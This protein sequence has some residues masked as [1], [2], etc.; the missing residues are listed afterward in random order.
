MSRASS[1]CGLRTSRRQYSRCP[2]WTAAAGRRGPG[3]KPPRHNRTTPAEPRREAMTVWTQRSSSLQQG[4]KAPDILDGFECQHGFNQSR[5]V[6]RPDDRCEFEPNQP[7]TRMR[8]TRGS[9]RRPKRPPLRCYPLPDLRC[10]VSN[11]AA[12]CCTSSGKSAIS[13]TCR[14]SMISLS[15]AGQRWAQAIASSRD[16]TSII[17]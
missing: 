7:A 1:T 12:A 3:C 14:I 17:Q 10:I 6:G 15:E 4:P 9:F 13:C 8:R 11:P 2:A 5:R 16:A